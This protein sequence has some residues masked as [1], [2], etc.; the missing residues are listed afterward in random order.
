MQ[1]NYYRQAVVFKTLAIIGLIVS[2][3]FILLAGYGLVAFLPI[4]FFLLY[5]RRFIKA[6]K[7]GIAL[8]PKDYKI[9]IIT[10]IFGGAGS[11]YGF[12]IF[13]EISHG[14]D[15]VETPFAPF[16]VMAVMGCPLITGW[17]IATSRKWQRACAKTAP[18]LS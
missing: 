7:S 14:V 15:T 9:F 18:I 17:I 16:L 6:I 11:A 13:W 5:D 8:S 4:L 2:A 12:Y 1:K 3:P 10:A